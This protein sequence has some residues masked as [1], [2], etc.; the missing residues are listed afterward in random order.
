M[1]VIGD[2]RN[3]S[4]NTLFFLFGNNFRPVSD[5]CVWWCTR[6]KLLL[7]TRFFYRL[8]SRIFLRPRVIYLRSLND[9]LTRNEGLGL[10]LARVFLY[11]YTFFKGG[12][13]FK[14]SSTLLGGWPSAGEVFCFDFS[15]S[16]SPLVNVSAPAGSDDPDLRPVFVFPQS[17]PSL[18]CVLL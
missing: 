1:M 7:F 13:V 5:V 2:A 14:T 4:R 17:S 11:L 3:A 9:R 18:R 16:Q 10:Q 15:H 12:A 6:K 8:A